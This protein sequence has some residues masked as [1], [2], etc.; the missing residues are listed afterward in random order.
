MQYPSIILFLKGIHS[1]FIGSI[2]IY[3]PFP[4]YALSVTV[5]SVTSFSVQ[6]PEQGGPLYPSHQKNWTCKPFKNA[7]NVSDRSSQP[8]FIPFSLM[9]RDILLTW[10][11]PLQ[12]LRLWLWLEVPLKHETRWIPLPLQSFL[13]K[14]KLASST[15][16]KNPCAEK[17]PFTIGNEVV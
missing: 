7:R 1:L 2:A 4:F 11:I 17:K 16:S 12:Q 14:C 3:P 10:V 9:R 8:P 13:K 15:T 6:N 5:L